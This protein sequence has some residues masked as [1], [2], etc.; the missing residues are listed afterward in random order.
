MSL[1]NIQGRMSRGEMKKIMAGSG[2]AC[3]CSCSSGQVVS[4]NDCASTACFNAVYAAC[5]G[6]PAEGCTAS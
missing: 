3:T 4:C 5:G 2:H 6:Q 1:A